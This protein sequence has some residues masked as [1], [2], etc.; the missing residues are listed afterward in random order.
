MQ[1]V[2]EI[3]QAQI[4]PLGEGEKLQLAALILEE[5]FRFDAG[6]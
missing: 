1:S 5:V 4:R 3:Y 6:Q 2:K